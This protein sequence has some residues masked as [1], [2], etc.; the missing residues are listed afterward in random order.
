MRRY[1]SIVGSR[2]GM[3]YSE[4]TDTALP[5]RAASERYLLDLHE[6][7][8]AA[9]RNDMPKMHC[10]VW[11]P[12]LDRSV[13]SRMPLRVRTWNAFKAAG[14][15]RGNNPL[16]VRDL[17]DLQ[18]FG[19]KSLTD[20]ILGIES[21]LR[22]CIRSDAESSDE[23]GND[24][25]ETH[26]HQRI[27]PAPLVTPS[28][29]PLKRADELMIPLLA[30]AVD[31]YGAKT[32]ASV[33]HPDLVQLAKRIGISS[34]LE[35]FQLRRLV[36]GTN[37]PVSTVS[38]RLTIAL[39]PKSMAER[40][41]LKYRVL[42]EPKKTL[43]EV[44]L[45][46]GVT[47]ERIRQIRSRI[48][49]RIRDSLGDEINLLASVL[50]EEMGHWAPKDE[51]DGRID[52]LLSAESSLVRKVFCQALLRVM[53]YALLDGVYFDR[54]VSE[55]IERLRSMTHLA[56]DV[57]LVREEQLFA[58]LPDEEWSP[59]WPWL[60]RRCGLHEIY[61]SLGVRDTVKARA[62]AALI[63][64]GRP[65]TREEISQVCG[66][67]ASRL[68]GYL[69]LIPSV[70]RA[71][72]DRWGLSEWVDDEYDGIVGEILQRIEEDGGATTTERLLS[73]L[74][75]KF[76]VN[77]NSV[78]AYMQ[79]PKFS[80]RDGWISVAKASSLQLRRL[81][82]VIHGRDRDGNPYWSFVVDA[83]LFDG[84]SL[85][86]VPPELAKALGCEPDARMS[87]RVENLVGCRDLSLTW[88][89]SSITGASI[90]YLARPLQRLGLHPGE[91]A[92]VAIKDH[93]LVTVT[94]M[95]QNMIRPTSSS[96]DAKLAQIMDRRRVL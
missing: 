39:G 40:A 7:L 64:I 93:G 63:S 77:S 4:P 85:T 9:H 20:L 57:G 96:A 61:G 22:E 94:A 31:I 15:S 38:D 10:I 71:S 84:F 76:E 45:M 35:A 11:P 74:P 36:E 48:E 69:S 92:M 95:D 87:V 80:I 62:K 37:G 21:F 73:E 17:L 50:K 72:K 2:N 68:S 59:L 83:R 53:D 65:A 86:G 34:D 55:V 14:L 16:T 19:H 89:L 49:R 91:R 44:G 3:L 28:D 75:N 5:S 13:L 47:R 30:A 25:E 33:F 6:A 41:V 46:V 43:Q 67:S 32:L 90:G 56:D 12:G 18:N 42:Q 82:D 88:R 51:V 66:L 79:S 70:V 27:V 23:A 52:G 78:R 26:C 1:R 81:D 54:Q 58:E 60:R 8:T 24:T 29:L